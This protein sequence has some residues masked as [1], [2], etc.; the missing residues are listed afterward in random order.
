MPHGVE[1]GSHAPSSDRHV[2]AVNMCGR[3]RTL[4]DPD[5]V[6]SRQLST[7]LGLFSGLL[8]SFLQKD[9]KVKDFKI[10]N[11]KICCESVSQVV[12]V[13]SAVLQEF[14]FCACVWCSSA[15][16]IFF[17]LQRR[18]LAAVPRA[19]T[20]KESSRYHIASLVSSSYNAC[21]QTEAPVHSQTSC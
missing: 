9:Q 2:Q 20:G 5:V 19:A 6:M 11:R 10:Y 4:F 15:E 13:L 17:F 18:I 14:Y 1:S 12:V 8:Y 21:R 7:F 3:Q 16:G